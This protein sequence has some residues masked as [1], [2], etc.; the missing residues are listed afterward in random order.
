VISEPGRYIAASPV[1]LMTEVIGKALRDGKIWYY[2]DDGLYSSFSGMLFD[3]CQYPVISTRDGEPQL[4]VL[5]GPT[6]DSFDVMYDGLMMAEH[7]VG[8][9]I[10]FTST[11]AYCS[12]SGSS[13]NQLKRAEYVV[14][15]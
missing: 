15:D 2:L 14:I 9:K 11:G 5:S 3:H 1:V 12:V 4:S 7:E 8:D 6:C 13:F 10:M